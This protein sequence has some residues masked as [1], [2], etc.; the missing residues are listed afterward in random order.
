MVCQGEYWRK[1]FI[2]YSNNPKKLV[3]IKNWLPPEA[4]SKPLPPFSIRERNKICLVYLGWIERYKGLEDLINAVAICINKHLDVQLDI[5][6][7][8]SY[9][10][11]ISE[12]I[13]S[14]G[15]ENNILLKG[16]ANDEDKKKKKVKIGL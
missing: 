9:K 13:K 7:E 11:Q 10:V 4:V 2:S 1:V 16:W 6:G 3:V 5:W 8:G 15:L 14:K 12:L